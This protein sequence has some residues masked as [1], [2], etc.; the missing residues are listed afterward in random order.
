M[1]KKI[2]V[3]LFVALPMLLAASG[4]EVSTCTGDEC[5]FDSIFDEDGGSEDGGNN[6]G[7][8]GGGDNGGS[9]EDAGGASGDGGGGGSGGETVTIE[10]FCTAQL[11][12]GQ[13]WAAKFDE[14][15]SSGVAGSA[16]V[17]NF[18]AGVLLYP[19]M[20]FDKCV[21]ARK[22]PVD[23]G[24][25]TF[26]G[27]KAM[28]CATGFLE[29]YAPP[30]TMCP[31]AGFDLTA[32]EGMLGHGAAS[33]KQVPACREAFAG[34]VAS[35]QPCT[36]QFECSGDLRCRIFSGDSN[37]T[38]QPALGNGATCVSNSDCADG[39]TCVGDDGQ[40]A[41]GRQCLASN[42]DLAFSGGCKFSSECEEGRVCDGNVCS[43]ATGG[44]PICSP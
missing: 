43:A 17:K 3:S 42:N 1:M 26:N 33:L 37:K 40:G 32:L 31:V 28:A 12:I 24:K 21:T 25:V 44:T 15:C 10:E 18:L 27:K 9:S 38:C 41:A 30:A 29:A 22:T 4:C 20:A 19:D 11:A 5:D 2:S 36:D 6:G 14:C 23:A 7:L 16:D 35:G 39:F 13:A 34:T 8:D